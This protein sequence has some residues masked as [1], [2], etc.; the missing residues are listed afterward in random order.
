MLSQKSSHIEVWIYC[1]RKQKAVARL[2]AVRPCL[3]SAQFCPRKAT[4]GHA[5]GGLSLLWLTA[6][7]CY[8][9][10]CLLWTPLSLLLSTVQWL[11]AGLCPCIGKISSSKY[12]PERGTI[13][14]SVTQGISFLWFVDPYPLCS[15]PLSPS[16]W[17]CSTEMV[18]FRWSPV[19]FISPSSWFQMSHLPHS[20]PP[21]LQIIFLVLRSYPWLF[22]IVERWSSCVWE[23]RKTV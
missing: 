2:S 3:L 21:A 14:P 13:S 1:G 20:L 19:V 15:L 23:M 22:R 17:L 12:T 10:I 16:L 18:P 9:V 7:S 4:T 6:K 8:K 11:P 5:Q